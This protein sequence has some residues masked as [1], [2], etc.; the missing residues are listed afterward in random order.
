MAEE[1]IEQKSENTDKNTGILP[2]ELYQEK[3]GGPFKEGNPGKPKGAK[4]PLSLISKLKATLEEI[5]KTQSG[6]ERERAE[7]LIKNIVYMAINEKDKDMIKLIFNYVEGLPKQPI[8]LSGEI[9]NPFANLNDNEKLN[10]IRLLV[11]GIGKDKGQAGLDIPVGADTP[12]PENGAITQGSGAISQE[13]SDKQEGNN[14]SAEKPLENNG[15]NN[16]LDNSAVNQ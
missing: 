7:T 5:S 11:E 10:R 2:T 13:S 6:E 12:L 14:S 8:E 1:K 3:P 9:N 15:N 4:S 16:R